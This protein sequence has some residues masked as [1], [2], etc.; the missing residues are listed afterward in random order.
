M[1]SVPSGIPVDEERHARFVVRSHHEGRAAVLVVHGDIDL[2]TVGRLSEAAWAA[3]ALR[4]SRLALD[5]AD[6]GFFGLVGYGA[7]LDLRVPAALFECAVL[8]RNPSV[9]VRQVFEILPPDPL[10]VEL[11]PPRWV[12]AGA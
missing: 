10:P 11:H 6:V 4:P 7:L 3:F 5:F 8:V 2:R 12:A 9:A 1:A